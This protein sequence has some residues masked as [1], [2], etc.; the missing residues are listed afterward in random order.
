MSEKILEVND[1]EPQTIKERDKS[2]AL[3]AFL[4]CPGGVKES[5]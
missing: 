1:K 2:P 3:S 4:H 5:S